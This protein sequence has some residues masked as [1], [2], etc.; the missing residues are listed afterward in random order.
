MRKK[1]LLCA[2]GMALFITGCGDKKDGTTGASSDTQAVS[3]TT[4]EETVKGA[5]ESWGVYEEILVPE[6]M[7][8]TGG[9]TIDK[10]DKNA[11]WVQKS[12]DAM[13]YFLFEVSNEE[14]C[15]KDVQ[16][17]KEYNKDSNPKDVTIKTGDY[18]WTGV[19]YKYDG[20]SGPMDIS[21]MYAKVGNTVINVRIGGFAYDSDLSKSILASLKVKAIADEETTS[22]AAA[23]TEAAGSAQTGGDVMEV[24]HGIYTIKYDAAVYRPSTSGDTFGDLIPL[25][26]TKLPKLYVTTLSGEDFLKEKMEVLER[27]AAGNIE[28]LTIDGHTAYIYKSASDF[29]GYSYDLVIPFTCTVKSSDGYYNKEN[30]VYIYGSAD[31]EEMIYNDTVKNVMLSVDIDESLENAAGDTTTEAATVE[32]TTADAK[33]NSAASDPTYGKSTADATGYVT[34]EVL[35]ETYKWKQSAGAGLTYEEFRDHFGCDGA[36]WNEIWKEDH[37]GY[38]WRTEDGDFL[39][40]SFSV[41]EDGSEIYSSCTYSDAVRE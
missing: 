15:K 17:T 33:N 24:K 18:E 25:D 31:A 21:Q 20:Y 14:Q 16:A 38:K 6:G 39:H 8:L 23:T 27:D 40:V 37:H 41:K 35:Q 32:E 29:M 36:I 34:L 19:A 22:E 4:A 12:N 30:A 7:K 3:T 26:E 11:V 5:T 28:Q 2:L 9:T 10:E 1:L 13:S